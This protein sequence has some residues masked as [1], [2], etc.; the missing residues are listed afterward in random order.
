MADVVTQRGPAVYRGT[1]ARVE[2]MVVGLVY[3][4][5]SIIEILIGLRFALKLFG[6]NA[7]A[8]FVQFVYRLS[9]GLM[10]PFYAVFATEQIRGA[11]FDWSALL[12]MV[13][14]GLIA[15][16][17]VALIYAI[18]PGGGGTAVEIQEVDDDR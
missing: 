8:P 10:A 17:I 16:A 4:V 6:A 11:V 1:G 12:A 18:D 15:W 14:Y 13:V 7:S 2:S 9:A 3:W 5:F